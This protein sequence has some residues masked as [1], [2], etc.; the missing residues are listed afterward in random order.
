MDTL[1]S[2]NYLYD[3]GVVHANHIAHELW[4]LVP[5]NLNAI[6]GL[7]SKEVNSSPH[8]DAVIDFLRDYHKKM[9]IYSPKVESHLQHLHNGTI[10]GGQ[11]PVILG[12]PGFIANKMSISIFLHNLID[13]AGFDL[14]PV[15]MIGDYDGLQK[16]LTRVY[17]P[18]PTSPN[19]VILDIT[20][21][22][23]AAEGTAAHLVKLPD[24][25]WLD[26]VMAELEQA[27][28]GFRKK[29]K[30]DK[31]K[32]YYERF[33]HIHDI[34][35]IVYRES[36]RLDDF[37]VRLWGYIANVLN[38]FG[39]IFFPT[40]ALELKKYYVQPYLHF[41]DNIHQYVTE[42]SNAT[43]Q[44]QTDGYKPSLPLRDESYSPFFFEC[45]NDG[46]RINPK[47]LHTDEGRFARGHCPHCKHEFNIPVN[48]LADLEKISDRLGPRVDTSQFVLQNLLNVKVRISGPGEIAYYAQVACSIR[49]IGVKTPVFVKYKRLFYNVPWNEQLGKQLSQRNQGAI[50]KPELFKILKMRIVGIREQN[51][52]KI[53]NAEVEL[54][55][56]ILNEYQQLLSKQ[57][58]SD[59]AKYLSWMYGRFAPQKFGQEVSWSWIDMAL[60]T[61]LSDYLQT[62]FRMYAPSSVPGFMYFTN[63]NL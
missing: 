7:M 18:N 23:T 25:K 53:K 51:L 8:V 24:E 56:F 60:Q 59:P 63:T 1:K 30:G 3:E 44:L 14:A 11:Q 48:T 61:G 27:V 42:F 45:A 41:L 13:E 57:N 62:F 32:L 36:E 17:F 58:K 12:G 37:F 6:Y 46:Y 54:H 28:H 40:S 19:A 47:I 20:D 50:H 5:T 39:V 21:D 2:P 52:S 38:D 49:A 29:L 35:K 4:G 16:E 22:I 9:K 55:E 26:R 43:M 33:R 31:Q 15:F 34:I 10:L